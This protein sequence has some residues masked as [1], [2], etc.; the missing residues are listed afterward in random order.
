MNLDNYTFRTLVVS[1][2]HIPKHTAEALDG[3]L[4]DGEGPLFTV[5]SYTRWHDYGWIIYCGE[6]AREETAGAGHKELADLIAFAMDNGFVYLQLDCD[7]D[8]LPKETGLPE[9]EW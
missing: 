4:N 9:F 1:T 3:D 8:L 7:A 6:T 5:L 2:G